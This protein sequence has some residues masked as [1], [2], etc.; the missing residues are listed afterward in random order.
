MDYKYPRLSLIQLYFTSKKM[1]CTLQRV[2]KHLL[3]NIVL[4]S[5]ENK[6]QNCFPFFKNQKTKGNAA[7]CELSHYSH[8]RPHFCS[9]LARG[10]SFSQVSHSVMSNSLLWHGLQH[11]RLP[12]PSPSP[13][14]CSNSCPLSLGLSWIPE[15]EKAQVSY[16]WSSTS[17]GS[18]SLDREGWRAKQYL[19][20]A[21]LISLTQ[22][23]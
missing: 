6:T 3:L 17:L 15:S 13:K 8:S 12:Y 11:A 2:K 21:V 20:T 23:C 1:P 7:Y 14:A 9:G 19:T 16:S 10:P 5:S 4:Y 22:E 18:T